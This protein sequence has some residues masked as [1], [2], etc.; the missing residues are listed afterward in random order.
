MGRPLLLVREKREREK[1]ENGRE[2]RNRGKA[3]KREA[4]E[5]KLENGKSPEAKLEN[6]T[7]A[8][9]LENWTQRLREES[10]HRGKV[11]EAKSQRQGLRGALEVRPQRQ[12][13]RGSVSPMR[14]RKQRQAPSLQPCRMDL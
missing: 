3:G 6:G 11:S 9:N 2:K 1:R 8:T 10:G 13:L 5:G 7:E 12:D 14:K 4:S